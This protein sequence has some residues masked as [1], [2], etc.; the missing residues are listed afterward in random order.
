MLRVSFH[1]DPRVLSRVRRALFVISPF[2]TCNAIFALSQPLEF[3]RLSQ[4]QWTFHFKTYLI[5]SLKDAAC[6]FLSGSARVNLGA[7]GLVCP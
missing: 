4:R 3:P 2:K 5:S 6:V 7:T 1:A